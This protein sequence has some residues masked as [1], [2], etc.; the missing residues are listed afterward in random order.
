ML[1]KL[2]ILGRPPYQESEPQP[3]P[4][5]SFTN[6]YDLLFYQMASPTCTEVRV[7]DTPRC[8]FTGSSCEEMSRP[9]PVATPS[10]RTSD[11]WPSGSW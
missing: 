7:P 6:G 4:V 11:A 1:G 10:R 3:R 9:F 8:L 2:K 5:L